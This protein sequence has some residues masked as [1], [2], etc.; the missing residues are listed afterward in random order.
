L[1]SDLL[2]IAPSVIG[3]VAMA[4]TLV[5]CGDSGPE[6][7]ELSGQVTYDGK[8]IP[9]GVITFEPQG[10]TLNASTMGEAEIQAGRYKTL[11]E[12]GIVGGQH[13]V[14]I[15]GY[16][17]IPEPGSGPYGASLFAPVY[18]TSVQLPAEPSSLDFDVPKD[19]GGLR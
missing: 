18:K 7:Y 16:N 8:P 19:V 10:I 4:L 3:I 17:G 2:P 15:A 11:P 12:K 5:G 1:K 13:T 9:A 6:R 14:F